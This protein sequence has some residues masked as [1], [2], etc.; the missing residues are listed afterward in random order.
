MYISQKDAF[1]KKGH[2]FGDEDI[3]VT[4]LF[5]LNLGDWRKTQNLIGY[6]CKE[7]AEKNKSEAF[8]D[9]DFF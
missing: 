8:S 6:D 9:R 2:A 1:I 5:L 3:I 7:G 4:Q